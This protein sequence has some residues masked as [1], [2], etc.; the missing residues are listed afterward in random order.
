MSKMKLLIAAI[1][2]L[3]LGIVANAADMNMGTKNTSAEVPQIRSTTDSTVK[4]GMGSMT[5]GSA[6]G[7]DMC[8]QMMAGMMSGSTTGSAMKMNGN[9]MKS[10]ESPAEILKIR[11]AKGEITKAQYEEIKAILNEDVQKTVPE[12]KTKK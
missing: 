2:M 10:S 9:M 3:T 8:K 4:I 6:M 11:L 7:M 12:A 5:T 1:G